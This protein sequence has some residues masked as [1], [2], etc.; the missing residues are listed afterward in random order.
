MWI[1]VGTSARIGEVLAL[2][3]RRCDVDVTANPPTVLIVGTITQT[4]TEGIRRKPTPNRTR[5]K[6]RIALPSFTAAAI[7]RQLAETE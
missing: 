6:R 1:M 3:L 7:R 5:L 4:R 2:A